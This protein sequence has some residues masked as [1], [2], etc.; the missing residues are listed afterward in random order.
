M[1]P[2]FCPSTIWTISLE[3]YRKPSI[4]AADD[5][6]RACYRK[7]MTPKKLWTLLFRQ[8]RFPPLTNNPPLE[9]PK[10]CLLWRVLEVTVA[11]VR[12]QTSPTT[13]TESTSGKGD[14]LRS[15]SLPKGPFR[16]VPTDSLSLSRQEEHNSRDF[17]CRAGAETPLNF[18]EKFGDCILNLKVF[19]WN[20]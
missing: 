5:F 1:V 10:L 7:A 2:T 13:G 12:R 4:L 11:P 9:T 14:G 15:A 6:L 8:L 20:S 3:L 18:R 19:L 17:I 16:T